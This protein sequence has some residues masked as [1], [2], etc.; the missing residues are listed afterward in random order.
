M[1]NPIPNHTHQ[2][3]IKI[4]TIDNVDCFSGL[5]CECG[6][7]LTPHTLEALAN[8]VEPIRRAIETLPRPAMLIEVREAIQAASIEPSILEL[9]VAFGMLGLFYN[10][11]LA[12]QL[13]TIGSAQ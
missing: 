4:T 10:P 9:V 3:E 8:T 2:W 5:T 6:A 13:S 12:E 7:L 11:D 1:N